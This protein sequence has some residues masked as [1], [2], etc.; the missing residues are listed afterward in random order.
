MRFIVT[1]T[2]RSGTRYMSSLFQ[3]LNVPCTHERA[4]RPDC[5]I[6]DALNW[7]Q[8]NECGESSWMAWAFLGFLPGPVVMFHQRRNP[9][10]VIDSLSARNNIVNLDGPKTPNHEKMRAVMEAYCP[11]VLERKNAI[12]RAAAFLLDWHMLIERATDRYGCTYH[13][14]CVEALNVEAVQDLL[15]YLDI[16]RSHAS[17]E[18][19]LKEVATT[20][21]AGRRVETDVPISDPNIMAYLKSKHPGIEPRA[22]RIAVVPHG[23]HRTPAELAEPRPSWPT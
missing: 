1:G 9:W 20:N 13:T 6:V 12:D 18:R 22:Q 14:Y 4:F 16:V 5:N 21:N 17:I 10:D 15:L 2:P 3:S 7:Y 19:S 23:E 11:R 8:A